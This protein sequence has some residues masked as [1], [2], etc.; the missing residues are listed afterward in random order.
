MALKGRGR[1]DLEVVGQKPAEL[2]PKAVPS[3][4]PA[5]RNILPKPKPSQEVSGEIIEII[6]TT[7][8]I[9]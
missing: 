4:M 1:V 8:I 9:L 6:L 7:T 5:H 2:L 3:P